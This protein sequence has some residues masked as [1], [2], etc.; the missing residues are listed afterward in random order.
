VP[1]PTTI[2]VDIAKTVFEIAVSHEIGKVAQRHR[3][4]RDRFL[5]FFAQRES[6]TVLL[7]ASS[8]AHHWARALRELEHHPVLLPPKDVRPYR[9][10]NKTD[11][12]DA[13]ALL[14]AYRDEDLRPVPVKTLHQQ[15]LTGLHRLRSAWLAARTARIN[16]VR[17][18]LR[19]LG[20]TIPLGARHVVP[21]TWALLED[22]EPH[23]PDPLRLALAEACLEIRDL[24]Q[25]LAA[26][27]QQLRRLAREIPAVTHL[28]SIPGIGLVTS[29]A[30]VAF[31]GDIRRFPTGRHFAS[32]LGITPREHSSGTRRRLGGI[33]KRGD[34]YLRMLL[35]HGARSVLWAAKRKPR[36]GRL[37]A[38]ARDL[39]ARRGHNVAAVGLANKLARIVWAVWKDG[40][41]FAPEAA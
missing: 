22:A 19:E 16:T 12:A 3:V 39:E 25:R 37:R 35:I 6:A 9:R 26:V 31:V 21:R 23:V 11:R 17:G 36:P 1:Q 15:T 7:E 38:W 40:R 30:L 8:S 28:L 4:G 10:G 24:E 41:D 20:H 13:K 32:Y 29:T 18:I 27:E 34:T 5:R 33:T 2:A 14:E